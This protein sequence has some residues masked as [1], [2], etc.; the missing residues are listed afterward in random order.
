MSSPVL[1][2]NIYTHISHFLIYV[3]IQSVSPWNDHFGGQQ[4]Q[5]CSSSFFLSIYRPCRYTQYPCRI[6]LNNSVIY[7]T[8]CSDI[9]MDSSNISHT[10]LSEL[11]SMSDEGG[12]LPTDPGFCSSAFWDLDLTWNTNNPDFTPCFHQTVLTYIPAVVIILGLPFQVG[13]K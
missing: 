8:T 4:D 13:W 12:G 5:Y 1:F 7:I 2:A 3:V 6:S 11:S 9:N 10:T